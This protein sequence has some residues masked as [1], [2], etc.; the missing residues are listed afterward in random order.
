MVVDISLIYKKKRLS[1][2]I[3]YDTILVVISLM[4]LNIGLVD[5]AYYLFSEFE[6]KLVVAYYF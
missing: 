1:T 4:N 6:Y 5:G 2:Y 3:N